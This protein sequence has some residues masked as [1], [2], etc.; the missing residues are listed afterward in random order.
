M[1]GIYVTK[2]QS[3]DKNTFL[4]K[5]KP[6]IN[7]FNK[8]YDTWALVIAL[9]INIIAM[10]LVATA[11]FDNYIPDNIAIITFVDK[12]NIKAAVCFHN[13]IAYIGV[14]TTKNL[15]EPS[16]LKSALNIDN[17]KSLIT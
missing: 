16:V 1:N 6:N 7:R 15:F 8:K 5:F 17:Y 3:F 14:K 11:R 2:H 10:V 13:G 12:H 4:K 9:C